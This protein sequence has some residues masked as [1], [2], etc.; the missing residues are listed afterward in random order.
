VYRGKTDHATDTIKAETTITTPSGAGIPMARM[1]Q[2]YTCTRTIGVRFIL[3][4][5]GNPLHII[6]TSGDWGPIFRFEL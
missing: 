1:Q 3:G 4:T 5:A 6:L 2:Q